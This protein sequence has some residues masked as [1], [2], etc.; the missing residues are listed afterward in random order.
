MKYLYPGTLTLNRERCSG[1]SRCIEVCPHAVFALAERKALI[2]DQGSCMECGACMKNCP[3]GAIGVE[4]GTGCAQA[5]LKSKKSGSVECGCN[6]SS[7]CG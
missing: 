3:V 4:I 5:I 6:S 2:V 7:C 1:C